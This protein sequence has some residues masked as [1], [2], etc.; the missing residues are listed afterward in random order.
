MAEVSG[1][2]ELQLLETEVAC[3]EKTLA[4]S[5]KA[6]NTSSACKRV[7]SKMNQMEAKDSFVMTEGMEPNQ[8]HTSAGQGSDG[9]C[10]AVL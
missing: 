7:L 6:E 2:T 8:Y 1:I 10:C 3:L 4:A 5:K 9:G